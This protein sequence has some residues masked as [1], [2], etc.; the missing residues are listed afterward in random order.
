M[1]RSPHP[2]PGPGAEGIKQV[3]V[4]IC[5]MRMYPVCVSL[6]DNGTDGFA[7]ADLAGWGNWEEV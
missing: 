6:C 4:H 7:E 2:S 3:C 5:D 1:P